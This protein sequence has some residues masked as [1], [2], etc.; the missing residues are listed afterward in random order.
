[1]TN[2][3][4]LCAVEDTL[5]ERNMSLYKLQELIDED[6]IKESTFYGHSFCKQ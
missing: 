2:E 6:I 4:F 3:E 1:M 5:K